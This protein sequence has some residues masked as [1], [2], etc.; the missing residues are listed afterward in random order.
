MAFQRFMI[1]PFDQNS[2]LRNNVKP[3][4]IPDEAFAEL[5]NAYVFRGRV[6]KRFGSTYMNLERD[7]KASRFRVACGTLAAPTSPVPGATGAAG[8]MFS[9]ADVVFTAVTT[10]NLLVGNGSATT[11]TFNFATGAFVFANV[12]DAAGNLVNVATTIYWYPALPVMGLLTYEA[13]DI[14]NETLIG[15][16][17]RYAYGYTTNGWERLA[18][19]VTANAATWAGSDAQ[20]FWGTTWISDAQT[21]IFFVTNF[22]EA[23]TNFMRWYNGTNWD[24]FRPTLSVYAAGPPVVWGITL[25]TARV[26]VVFK[27]R[28]VAFNTF[29][30][31]TVDNIAFNTYH[32][33]NRVRYAA[34]GNPLDASAWRQDVPGKGNFLDA[35]TTEAIVTVEF[36]RDRLVV[37]FERSTWELIYTGNQAYPFAWQQ[38]NT[39]LGAE[40][41]FSVI[42]FD[43]V[44]LGIGNVGIHSCSGT[45]VQRIDD[46]IPNEVYR[47]HNSGSGVFRVYGIRDYFTEVV[48]WSFPTDTQSDSTPFPNRV[49]VFNYK[50]GTWAFNDDSI[51]AFG[52]YYPQTGVTWDSTEVTW[53]DS[54]SWSS[55]FL[56]SQ[57]QKIV[58]GNQQG[59]TF[60][61]DI[62]CPVNASVLQI[63]NITI[64]SSI[65]TITS[66]NHNLS[67]GD[68]VYCEGILGTNASLLNNTIL[69]VLSTAQNT[70]VV[71][72]RVTITNDYAG[73][74]VIS[75]VSQI[76]IKTKEYNFFAKDNRNA[77]L[78]QINFLVD[79]TDSGQIFVDVNASTN[80]TSLI[81]DAGDAP[82]GT[83]CLIG[84]S[85]LETFPYPTVSFE[86][87]ATRVWHPVYF[88]SEGEVVQF[89]LYLT[90]D[91]MRSTDIRTQDFVLHAFIIY[92]MPTSSRLQ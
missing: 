35:P 36:I 79:R 80:P 38:I 8:Q 90:D 56:Q 4:L 52:Y 66:Y 68:Y 49:L 13:G 50:T 44:A 91:M 92:A 6:R 67:A 88:Q 51:T 22:N 5:N 29:E 3:W 37:Y 55:G 17:T 47:I 20:L 1:A 2:G 64:A 19:E 70:F 41:T 9:I 30:R 83:G 42:P 28:L 73:G 24:N 84:T 12:R 53:D 10:G 21:K 25:E 65:V 46:V 72:T 45:N 31:V 32:Y 23:E 82:A 87:N 59:Y 74:G 69:E 14:N 16:D 33:P 57:T 85:V 7:Q 63:T 34:I 39:E 60:L 58:M 26:L 78:S 18:G 71:S 40:S 89:H 43:Q 27:N 11:A 54:V 81:A 61:L 76:S 62:D 75:R 48:Y 86:A 77:Y 15:F